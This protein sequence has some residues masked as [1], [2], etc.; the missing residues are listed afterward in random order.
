MVEVCS[1]KD[2]DVDVVSLFHVICQEAGSLTLPP[3]Y[4][5]FMVLTIEKGIQ[6]W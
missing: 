2:M 5:V 6:S 4:Q 3:F 1:G